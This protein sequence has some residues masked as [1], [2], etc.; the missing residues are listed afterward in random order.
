MP[1]SRTAGVPV[2]SRRPSLGFGPGPSPLGRLLLWIALLT[3]PL[4]SVCGAPAPPKFT[5]IPT[6][7]IGVSGGVASFV[8]QA[9]GHPKPVVYW[10]KKGK[11]VNS[12]RIE[13]VEFDEGAGAVLRIQPL[14]PP[15]DENIYECVARNSEGEVS[16]TAKLAIIREDLLPFGFPSI[17]MGPQLKVV[18]RTRTATMLCAASG[19]PDPEI[20]WFKDFLPIDPA[21]SQGRIKQL[22]SG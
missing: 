12:Q 15:R 8:C 7:Q 16:V 3:G 19:I 4:S 1:Q 9:S 20:S 13:T 11:K 10:N 6:D 18:E 2:Q 22:R 5:K 21:S 17:D 14:R